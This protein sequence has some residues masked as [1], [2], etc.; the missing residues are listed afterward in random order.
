MNLL[1]G[2]IVGKCDR[3]TRKHRSTLNQFVN[4]QILQTMF[5]AS[6]VETFIILIKFPGLSNVVRVLCGSLPVI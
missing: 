2:M 3:K 5:L 4:E 1:S 6:T